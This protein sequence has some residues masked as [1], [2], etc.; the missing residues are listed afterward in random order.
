MTYEDMDKSSAE[1][2]EAAWRTFQ[3]GD[4]DGTFDP[5]P[6]AIP[7]FVA[8]SARMINSVTSMVEVAALIFMDDYIF[9]PDMQAAINRCA[10]MRTEA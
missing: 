7:A 8:A 10:A 5:D 9:T 1:F 2:I 6:D 3:A 4:T